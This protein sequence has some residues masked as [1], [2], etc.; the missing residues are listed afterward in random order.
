MAEQKHHYIPEFYLKQWARARI[1]VS[2]NS[3][4]VIR[5]ARISSWL[6]LPILAGLA[7]RGVSI[8]CATHL[9]P[10]EDKYLNL[11]DGIA[12]LSLHGVLN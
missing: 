12:A 1:A 6:A 3:V 9:R 7:T 11:A 10:F 4:A 5:R 8:R 2:S